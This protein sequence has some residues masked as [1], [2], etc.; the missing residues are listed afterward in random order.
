MSIGRSLICRRLTRLRGL[1]VKSECVFV[2]LKRDPS[3]THTLHQTPSHTHTRSTVPSLHAPN[4]Y[5][6]AT[7]SSSLVARASASA[8]STASSASVVK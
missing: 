5:W 4:L 6:I 7:L 2:S 8:T 1:L 3:H